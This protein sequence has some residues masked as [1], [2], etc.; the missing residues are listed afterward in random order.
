MSK[1]PKK[2]ALTEEGFELAHKLASTAD[3][4]RHA[5]RDEID[6]PAY[7]SSSKAVRPPSSSNPHSDGRSN[8]KVKDDWG[9][10]N[11]LGNGSGSG[12]GG[13]RALVNKVSRPAKPESEDEDE[14]F[15]RQMEET[16]ELSRR[17]SSEAP[18]YR[19]NGRT[20]G[21]SSSVANIAKKAAQGFYAGQG[22]A[23]PPPKASLVVGKF[24]V[25]FG[26][27]SNKAISDFKFA[28]DEPFGYYYLDEGNSTQIVAIPSKKANRMQILSRSSSTSTRFSRSYARRRY[29]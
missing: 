10:G 6:R 1:R 20:L 28:A 23:E 4:P 14:L 8:G 16:L 24:S 13:G 15:N 7:S 2:F 29:S 26:V 17:E 19:S 22:P 25:H 21:Q 27:F 9:E 5:S 11:V 3:I 18:A 12:G